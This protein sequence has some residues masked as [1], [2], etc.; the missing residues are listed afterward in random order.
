MLACCNVLVRSVSLADVSL[1]EATVDA[2]GSVQG[3]E[4][5]HDIADSSAIL[6]PRYLLIILLYCASLTSTHACSRYPKYPSETAIPT[7][8]LA[9]SVRPAAL[10]LSAR[11][12]IPA[13]E[14]VVGDIAHFTDPYIRST[15]ISTSPTHSGQRISVPLSNDAT[16]CTLLLLVGNMSVVVDWNRTPLGSA[17]SAEG[18]EEVVVKTVGYWTWTRRNSCRIRWTADQSC[19]T[20]WTNCSIS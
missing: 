18:G 20:R 17:L 10:L 3:M 8:R 16:R 11:F 1:D 7:V 2:C 6:V 9:T 13:L 14:V 5:V 15:T 4:Q 19:P 12:H